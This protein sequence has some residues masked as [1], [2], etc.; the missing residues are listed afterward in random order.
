MERKG[1]E[2]ILLGPVH[3]QRS[4]SDAEPSVIRLSVNLF[5]NQIGSLSFCLIF[6]IFGLNV[7]NNIAQKR[8]GSRILIFASN[9]LWIFHY[10]KVSKKWEFWR[11]LVILSKS[12]HVGL[13]NLVYRYIMCTFMCVH[14]YYVYFQMCTCILCVLSGVCAKWSLWAKF[15]SPKFTQNLIYKFIRATFVGV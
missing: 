12:F 7:H 4:L 6:P 5:S 11:F 2:S 14:A 10:K 9:F 8:C 13:W 3:S 1:C 15:L